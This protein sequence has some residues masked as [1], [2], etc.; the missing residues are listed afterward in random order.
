MYWLCNN[1]LM[2]DRLCSVYWLNG[3]LLLSKVRLVATLLN[4]LLITVQ[5]LRDD[6]LLS[7]VILTVLY[8][9]DRSSMISPGSMGLQ[10]GVGCPET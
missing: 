9:A 3:D 1:L 5:W 2:W 6:L 10:N 7:C 8:L 4:S